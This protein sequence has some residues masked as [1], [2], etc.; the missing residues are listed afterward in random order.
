MNRNIFVFFLLTLFIASPLSA[1][2]KVYTNKDLER[3]ESNSANSILN[4]KSSKVS[5]D[6]ADANLYQVL[7]VVAD[8]AKKKDGV[9]IFVSPEISGKI[10][11]KM[12]DIPWA[13]LLRII[14]R[15]HNL[16]HSFIGKQTLMIYPQ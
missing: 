15:Q 10:T 16:S 2:T 7:Q 13:T 6:F 11:I 8:V 12:K 3:Y 14:M 1:K 9:D 4:L 5:V